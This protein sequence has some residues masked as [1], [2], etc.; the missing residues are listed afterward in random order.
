MSLL[1]LWNQI[2]FGY[3]EFGLVIAAMSLV[4]VIPVKI[5]PWQ[6]VKSFVELPSRLEKLEREFNDDRAFRW[7]SQIINRSDRI[8]DGKKL[9]KEVW[10]DTIVTIGNYEKYCA[11]HPEFRNELATMT[12]AFM[13]RK[14]FDAKE[15]NDFI[16]DEINDD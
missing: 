2:P 15:N 6:W 9:R 5:N 10:E 7:R 16:V 11:A 1:D 4:E 14:Y 12:I 3:R 8:Q 13:R